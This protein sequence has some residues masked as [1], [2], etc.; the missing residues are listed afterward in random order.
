MWPDAKVLAKRLAKKEWW[1][2]YGQEEFFVK[3]EQAK[4]EQLVT[5]YEPSFSIINIP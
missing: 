3:V 1:T 2:N 4:I 5:A